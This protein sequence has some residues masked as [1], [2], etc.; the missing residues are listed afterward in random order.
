MTN[1]G[2]G[3]RSDQGSTYVVSVAGPKMYPMA[4][5]TW[6]DRTA[7]RTQTFQ[8]LNVS[9]DA[10]VYRAFTATGRELDAFRLTKGEDGVAR[11]ETLEG[12]ERGN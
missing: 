8:T 12:E 2:P 3:H 6:A 10:V 5:L 4:D 1:A 9:Q 7:A 11:M